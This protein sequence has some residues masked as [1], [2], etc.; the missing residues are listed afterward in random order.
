LNREIGRELRAGAAE[1][2]VT[3][4]AAS[5]AVALVASGPSPSVGE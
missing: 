3:V 5:G 2:R 4:R 1:T